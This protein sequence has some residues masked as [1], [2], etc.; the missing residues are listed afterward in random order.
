MG[1]TTAIKLGNSK[2]D[3]APIITDAMREKGLMVGDTS[4]GAVMGVS[5]VARE[6]GRFDVLVDGF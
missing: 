2:G 4:R 1:D 3:P 5:E 6:M